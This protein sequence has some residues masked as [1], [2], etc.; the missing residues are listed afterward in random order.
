M[1]IFVIIFTLISIHYLLDVIYCIG[2]RWTWKEYEATCTGYIELTEDL[3]TE[4]WNGQFGSQFSYF[5]NREVKAICNNEISPY[6]IGK[7]YRILIPKD[8]EVCCPVKRFFQ[9][10]LKFVSLFAISLF[11]TVAILKSL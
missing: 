8:M 3:I 5:D 6:E 2:Q 4:D 1:I 11:A 10:Y 7:K 9:E